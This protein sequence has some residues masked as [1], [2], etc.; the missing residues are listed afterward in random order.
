MFVKAQHE[1]DAA[2][3][4]FL[5]RVRELDQPHDEIDLKISKLKE[6]RS[7]FEQELSKAESQFEKFEALIDEKCQDAAVE[8]TALNVLIQR[9]D[10]Q[11]QALEQ[12]ASELSPRVSK[13]LQELAA[14]RQRNEAPDYDLAW[15]FGITDPEGLLGKLRFAVL[16]T[17]RAVAARECRLAIERENEDISR[18]SKAYL[19]GLPD[20]PV[21]VKSRDERQQELN[22]SLDRSKLTPL[23][24]TAFPSYPSEHVNKIVNDLANRTVDPG[25]V[26]LLR[27]E[28]QQ[29]RVTAPHCAVACD[30]LLE[31][32]QQIEDLGESTQSAGQTM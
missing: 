23:I 1:R 20:L 18:R 3:E 8:V 12:K 29:K 14:L 27:I 28:A 2:Y 30:R 15:R 22:A 17:G 5:N 26:R 13:E 4:E 6:V 11:I 16:A 32:T 7:G 9:A 31:T 19:A 21:K 24:Q 25:F 10:R